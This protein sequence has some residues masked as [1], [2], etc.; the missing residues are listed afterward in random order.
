[1]PCQPSLPS[2]SSSSNGRTAESGSLS[3]DT[4]NSIVSGQKT[5]EAGSSAEKTARGVP[6]MRGHQTR[7][8]R[9]LVVQLKS[10][11][12]ASSS[13]WRLVSCCRLLRLPPSRLFGQFRHPGADGSSVKRLMSVKYTA[14]AASVS[15]R[16]SPYCD[17]LPYAKGQA[18]MSSSPCQTATERGRRPC[19][20]YLELAHS[21]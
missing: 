8:S 12:L 2:S 19:N 14:R 17:M 11:L 5:G 16:R 7:G 9:A 3:W 15:G 1:L 4:E 21:A 18:S 20:P 13:S 10:F 6:A